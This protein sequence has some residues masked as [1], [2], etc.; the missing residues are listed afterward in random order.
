MHLPRRNTVSLVAAVLGAACGSPADPGGGS[1]GQPLVAVGDTISSRLTAGDVDTF[2]LQPATSGLVAVYL[3]AQDS[4]LVEISVEGLGVPIATRASYVNHASLEANRTTQ[5]PVV[6]GTIY[7]VIVQAPFGTAVGFREGR[8]RFLSVAVDTAPENGPANAPLSADVSGES[9]SS[10]ADIDVWT[11]GAP[12]ADTLGLIMRV[13][14]DQPG[15]S[16]PMVASLRGPTNFNN[17]QFA[18]PGDTVAVQSPLVTTPD[19]MQWYVQLQA[20]DPG[21]YSWVK[22]TFPTYHFTV[23]VADL[24]PE[25]RT[26]VTGLADS[27]P[28]E[29]ID[30]VGDVDTYRLPLAASF[31]GYVAALQV[32]SGAADDTLELSLTDNFGQ[33]AQLIQSTVADTALLSNVTAGLAPLTQGMTVK[34]TARHL[35]NPIARPTYRFTVLPISPAPETVPAALAPGD[36]VT[37]EQ[38]DFAGD[39]DD[40]TIA[41]IA[42]QLVTADLTLPPNFGG[43]AVL[44]LIGVGSVQINPG[45]PLGTTPL[46]VTLPSTGSFTLRVRDLAAQMGRGHYRLTLQ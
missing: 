25:S 12:I 29:A 18:L 8:Y 11:I 41:G 1:G 35:S 26:A 21:P 44:D 13:S 4:N 2:R 27:L 37:S 20:A 45:A 43:P 34:V 24:R 6:A 14:L 42:N 40:F 15:S 31:M 28:V 30:S 23:S 36:T 33:G 46:T 39:V 7:R 22:P 16:V 5:F 32:A 19:L 38:I 10:S 17:Y 9:L 3:Q